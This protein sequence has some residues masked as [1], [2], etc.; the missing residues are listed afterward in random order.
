[1]A[2]REQPVP[3]FDITAESPEVA[4]AMLPKNI[5]YDGRKDPTPPP[6]QL[7]AGPLTMQFEPL[8]GFIRYVRIG[9]HEIVRAIY[10]AI[11]DHNWGTVPPHL[12]NLQQEINKDSFRL[13]FDV[14]CQQPGIDYVWHGT[15]TGADDGSISYSF[16]GEAHSTFQRNRIGICVLHPITECA[17]QPCLIEHS[18]G[19]HE[20][21]A[22]P[23]VIAPWQP[24]YDVRKISYTVAGVTAQVEFEGDEF[25]TEDQRNWSDASFKTYCTPQSLPKPATVHAGDKVRQLVKLT[26]KHPVKPVLPVVLGRP[27]QFS[28]S[29]TPVVPLPPIGFCIER[30]GRAL[31]PCD[32]ERLRALRPA[33]LRV[34]L[35]LSSPNYPRLLEAGALQSQQINAPLYVALVLSN[36][37]EREL[38]EL[39]EHLN[40]I[41][42]AVGLWLIFHE[43]QESAEEHW[44]KLARESL[45]SFTPQVLFAA[46]TLDFF[47][48]IN[49]N[50]PPA[51][52]TAFPCFSLNPQVHAFD[53]TTMVENLATQAGQVESA[54]EFSAKPVVLS[55]VT[56]RI[57]QKA[58]HDSGASSGDNDPR[59]MSLFGAGWTLG[60]IARL[61]TTG[62]VHSIT[63]FETIGVRGLI[64][65]EHPDPGLSEAPPGSVFPVYHVFA[66]II[67]F[68][69]LYPTHSS[70][71]LITEGLTLID[72]K[73]ARRLLVANLSSEPQNVKIKTGTCEGRVRYLD[74]TNAVEAMTAPEEFCARPGDVVQSA[75]GKIEL[76]LL[77]YALARVD[78][79]P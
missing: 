37:A 36:E 59:Q 52:A 53:N 15:I 73:G 9:D 44:V 45:Q 61:S 11:R 55:P 75:G 27:P 46:G 72:A 63:Y 25:E 51:S 69:R 49:R 62:N 29:T 77:P 31:T 38:R 47:T 1:M 6:L 57:R 43:K 68:Q 3:W 66:D 58:P 40:R 39:K 5:L 48:E 56:L 74:E 60:S 17:G 10:A 12:T 35:W 79:E 34:D 65:G 78:I 18:D 33:H 20:N 41:Q 2:Y 64:A 19:K 67:G 13:T 23:K 16:D 71:P 24:F 14:R 21:R 7:R 4:V 8:T 30:T 76:K 22:F 32:L 70:H 54:R 50:R 28:I 26:L 42:P